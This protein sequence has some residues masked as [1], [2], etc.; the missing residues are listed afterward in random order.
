M[1][2]LITGG[3]GFIGSS[4][5]DLLLKHGW[6]VDVIDDLSTGYH[7]NL[8][9][10][11]CNLDYYYGPIDIISPAQNT[12]VKKADFIFHLAATVGVDLVQKR[13]LDAIRR[14]TEATAV[15][16]RLAAIHNKKILIASSS[17]VY[18]RRPSDAPL[19]EDMDLHIGTEQRWGYAAGK[20]A[21]EFTAR[22]HH[23]E[24]GLKVV[25]ARLFNTIGP[26]QVSAHGMV[27]PSMIDAAMAGKP[28]PVIGGNQRRSFAWVG[29]V[30]ECLLGLIQTPSAYGQVVN[31]GRDS[32]ISIT[33]LADMIQKTV[34]RRTGIVAP[35]HALPYNR[36]WQDIQRRLPDLIK[37]RSLI[38]FAPTM[39]LEEMVDRL[40]LLKAATGETL[41]A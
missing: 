38:G 20:L 24:S 17:E 6:Y 14:N 16:L 28:I 35:I 37:L 23:A 9:V 33:A 3:A 4:L 29:E 11:P 18:G 10:G 5:V 2:A 31:V 22:A 12:Y 1:R 39:E 30:C 41:N 36:E 27:I 15:L 26:R 19:H 8:P 32:D 7:K 40:V 34:H 13:P 21:D 25:I